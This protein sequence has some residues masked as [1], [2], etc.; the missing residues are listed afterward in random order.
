MFQRGPI[1]LVL[2]GFMLAAAPRATSAQMRAELVAS[3]FTQ[4]VAFVQDPSDPTVQLVVEQGGR[5]RVLKNGASSADF[6]DLRSG[7]EHRRA[8]PARPRVRARLRGERPVLRELHE[9]RGHTVVARF[10]RSTANPLVAD[11]ASRFDLRL[12]GRPARSSRSRSRITT[13]A[14]SRSAPTAILYIGMGDGGSA[15][16]R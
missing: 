2:A 9:P 14:T 8:G 13:A 10:T 11:A 1:A 12:A 3:G 7:Q 6:L 16:T 15:T 4:P 5:I